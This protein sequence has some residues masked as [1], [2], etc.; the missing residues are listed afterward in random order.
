MAFDKRAVVS[1][2]D[3]AGIVSIILSVGLI[4]YAIFSY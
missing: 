1:F 2:I 3:V 4:A